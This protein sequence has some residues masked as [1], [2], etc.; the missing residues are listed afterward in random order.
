MSIKEIH[1][2][3]VKAQVNIAFKYNEK[4]GKIKFSDDDY[5]RTITIGKKSQKIELFVYVN[6]KK[7]ASWDTPQ[8]KEQNT[9]CAKEKNRFIEEVFNKLP[10]EFKLEAFKPKSNYETYDPANNTRGENSKLEMP[11]FK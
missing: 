10:I 4:D 6:P 3:L 1:D 2:Q 11:N 7:K 8:T 9:E 5:E